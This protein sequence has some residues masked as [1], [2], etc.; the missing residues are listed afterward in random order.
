MLKLWDEEKY[1]MSNSIKMMITGYDDT[2]VKLHLNT[3]TH[4]SLCGLGPEAETCEL[5]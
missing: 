5:R 1:N 4:S 3:H 2:D